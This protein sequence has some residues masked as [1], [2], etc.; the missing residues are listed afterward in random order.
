VPADYPD[1]AE[2]D[3]A[4]MVWDSA[5]MPAD[6]ELAG[7]PV[8]AFEMAAQSCDPALF[9]Y[10][11]DVAP[12]GRVTFITE[13]Q[14]RALHRRPGDPASLA[15][16]QGPAPHSFTRADRMESSPGER[17]RVEFALSSTAALIRA[18]HRLRI[19]LGGADAHMFMTY[20]DGVPE[21]FEVFCGTGGSTLTVPLRP[22]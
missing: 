16:D 4:L 20:S 3:A 5:P 21:R 12:D 9:V 19:A 1:R 14:F 15:Y 22:W 13:G 2:A 11:E 10:L 18:G 7:F 8:V 6:M 17:I